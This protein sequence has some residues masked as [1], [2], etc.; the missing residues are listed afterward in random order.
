M[1]ALEVSELPLKPL[2]C[3]RCRGRALLVWAGLLNRHSLSRGMS[4]IRLLGGG[5]SCLLL[6]ID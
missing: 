4:G 2:P 5:W 3:P 1:T 6:G